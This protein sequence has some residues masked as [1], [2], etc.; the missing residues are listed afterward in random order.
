M[1]WC[2]ALVSGVESTPLICA[3]GFYELRHSGNIPVFTF[4]WH[5]DPLRFESVDNSSEVQRALARMAGESTS[6]TPGIA[7]TTPEILVVSGRRVVKGFVWNQKTRQYGV[8]P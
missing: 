2:K 8:R 5:D 7:K 4:R 6:D 1:S 3:Y